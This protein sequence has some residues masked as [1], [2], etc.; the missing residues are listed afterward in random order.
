MQLFLKCDAENC[1]HVEYVD[2]IT[3]DM[4]GKECPKCGENLLTEEDYAFLLPL[5]KVK[6]ILQELRIISP[7]DSSDG[8]GIT[9]GCHKGKVTAS[10]DS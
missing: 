3:E 10:Y 5:E 7:D 4:I 6:N 8:I 9:I 2:D 1:D